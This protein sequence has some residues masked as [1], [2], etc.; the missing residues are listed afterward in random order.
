MADRPELLHTML[1]RISRPHPSDGQDER[2]RPLTSPVTGHCSALSANSG[3]SCYGIAGTRA[4]IPRREV[5]LT[6]VGC[7]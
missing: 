1:G 2:R 5:E 3:H 7:C 6:D 4:V